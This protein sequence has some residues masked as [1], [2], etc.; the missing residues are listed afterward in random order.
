MNDSRHPFATDT[1]VLG[2]LS[3]PLAFVR[4]LVSLAAVMAVVAIALYGWG[5]W[6][7]RGRTIAPASSK[8]ARTGFLAALAGLVCS[9]VMWVL[10]ASN[11]L[12]QH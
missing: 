2:V 6:R 9:I 5:R 11:W 10:W 7:A 1:L 4:H 8:H 12:L 3:V